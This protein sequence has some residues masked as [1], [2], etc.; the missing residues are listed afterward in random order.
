[1]ITSIQSKSTAVFKV[2][3][4]KQLAAYVN[5][6]F[7]RTAILDDGEGA[8]FTMTD[9]LQS[10]GATGQHVPVIENKIRQI[11]E[12]VRA[13][14]NTL[15]FN[16]PTTVTKHLVSP[17]VSSLNMMPCGTRVDK[18]SPREEFSGR[19]IDYK[20]DL[21]VAFGD[22]VQAH[23]PNVTDQEVKELKARTTST[24]GINTTVRQ[25]VGINTCH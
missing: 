12:C 7:N 1:M 9:Y 23:V 18:I 19:K 16:L 13:F 4:E 5:A 17:V 11:K 14:L 21:K 10:I 3:L 6:K 25:L 15:L 22:Y 20:R 24:I 2:A 8:V